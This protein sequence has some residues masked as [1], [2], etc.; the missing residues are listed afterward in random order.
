M[1]SIPGDDSGR[2]EPET[3]NVNAQRAAT[4][5]TSARQAV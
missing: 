1:R 4:A 2:L 5:E 3:D